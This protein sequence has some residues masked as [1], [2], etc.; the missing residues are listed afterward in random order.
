LIVTDFPYAVREIE[1]TLI[2][3]RDGIKLAARIWLPADAVR[4]PVP[5]KSAAGGMGGRLFRSVGP[6]RLLNPI[7]MK[8][9]EGI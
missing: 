4:G 1:H 3:L 9:S 7:A 6:R 8:L 2:P 5:A